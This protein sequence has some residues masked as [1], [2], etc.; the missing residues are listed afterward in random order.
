MTDSNV[1]A[2]ASIS[3][4]A[5]VDRVAIRIPEFCPSDPEMWFS[6]VERSFDAAGVTVET[7]KF[8]YVLGTLSARYAAEVRDIIMNPPANEPYKEL[9]TEFIRRLSASQEQK[10][11]RLLEQEEIGDRKPSQFLRHLRMLAGTFM[12]DGVLRT[13]WMGRLPANMQVI[14][15]TQRDTVLDKVA[16]LADAIAE[17]MTPRV[18]VAEAT[19]VIHSPRPAPTVDQ[20]LESLLNVKM[21]QLALSLRQEISAVRDS[22]YNE[23]SSFR[24]G[25]WLQRRRSNSRYRGRS[26]SRSRDRGEQPDYQGKCWYHWRYGSNA[27]RCVSPCN[28][29]PA[30]GNEQGS[31]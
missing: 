23:R 21:A 12:S 3:A 26:A 29:T 22:L 19:A 15:A 28:W 25:R 16:E 20:N 9:K 14:L 11:R 2:S 7:T 30:Q 8:G 17:T 5:A 4:S 1:N 6:M 13:L 24:R 31:R 27:H 10:T 18:Q